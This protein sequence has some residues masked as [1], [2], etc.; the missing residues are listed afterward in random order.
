[1]EW[2]VSIGGFTV[3]LIMGMTGMGG[4]LIMTPM[5][6]FLF[7][8]SPSVAVGTD[9]IYSS[10]TKLFG[11]YQHWRQKTVDLTLVKWL[12]AGSIPGALIGVLL[13][14]YLQ[15]H[16]NVTQF[17]GTIG[18]LLGV[19]YLLIAGLM[20]YRFLKSKP[21]AITP[22]ETAPGATAPGATTP[23]P[24]SLPYPPKSRLLAIGAAGGFVVGMTSVGSGTLFIALLL[25]VYPIAS[26]KLVGTDLLQAV[27]ITGTAGLAHLYIGNVNLKLVMELLIGSIPGILI[28]SRL[29]M[30]APDI[31]IRAALMLML[32]LSGM[33]FLN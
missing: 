11:A 13:I 26:N 5:M 21:G 16:L 32:V 17:N 20:L 6:I 3:G 30:K 2:E 29:T 4:A 15:H 18:K 12:S 14:F 25:F 24:S 22:G 23:G 9:L 33:K 8:V 27:L 28:G 31:A 19:I 1:M 7:G 10:I